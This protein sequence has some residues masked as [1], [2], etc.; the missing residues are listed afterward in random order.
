LNKILQIA[1]TF[2]FFAGICNVSY[3]QNS[4]EVWT[5][6]SPEIR[7]NIKNTP[8]EIRVRPDDHIFMPTKYIPSGNMGRTDI[9]IGAN[10]KKFKLFSYSKFTWDG[11][12]YTGARL[13]YNFSVAEGKLLFNIQERFFWG[14]NEQSDD[15]YY[16]VQYIRYKVAPKIQTGILSYG[17]WKTGS[18]FQETI[19]KFD[20][21]YWF[22]GPSVNF[23]LPK[24]FNIMLAPTKTVFQDNIYMAFLRLGWKFKV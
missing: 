2:V 14:L 10:I 12:A 7:L 20:K 4:I 22:I 15:H 9:M 3:S 13:D 8:L 21:G 11:D 16:L 5:K 6:L 19:E 1:L 23:S 24:G 17:K 18:D